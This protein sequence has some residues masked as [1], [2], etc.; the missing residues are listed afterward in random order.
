M[1][2]DMTRERLLCHLEEW[3]NKAQRRIQYTWWPQ[4]EQAYTQLVK[5]I[6]KHFEDNHELEVST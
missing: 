4:D 2:E 6:T 1:S 5:I 3:K